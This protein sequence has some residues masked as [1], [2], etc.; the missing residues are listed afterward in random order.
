M[1]KSKHPIYLITGDQ[2]LVDESVEEICTLFI[3]AER[4]PQNYTRLYA[5]SAADPVVEANS[6]SMFS[7][8][9][10]ILYL[11]FEACSA[12]RLPELVAYA[13]SPNPANVLVLAGTKYPTPARGKNSPMSQL[14][15]AIA[16]NGHVEELSVKKLNLRTYIQR[17]VSYLGGKI[18]PSAIS[19]L[20]QFSGHD[21]A[22]L[23]LEI[24][25]LICHAGPQNAIT[26]ADINAVGIFGAEEK[27][28]HFTQAIVSKNT[29]DAM[30]ALYRMLDQGEAPHRILGSVI[31]EFRKLTELQDSI[32]I[33][34][35][36]PVSWSKAPPRALQSA[37]QLLKQQPIVISQTLKALVDANRQFN[38]SKAGDR[39][40]LEALILRLCS[41]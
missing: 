12:E 41:L 40:H 1:T 23:N 3:G 28:W 34:G 18:E 22:I 33:R 37:Q 6:F 11:H 8:L 16:Q 24:Q 9:K 15:A 35:P 27:I 14:K 31:W 2:S 39:R 19:L 20:S 5:D 36:L 32:L 4:D 26:T 25:K 21:L 17:R 13:S 7:P 38:S 29:N 30:S 10:V